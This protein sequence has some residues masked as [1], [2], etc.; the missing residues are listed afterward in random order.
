MITRV[1]CGFPGVGK[2][3]FVDNNMGSYK[4]IDSDSSSYSW[5]SEGVRNPAFPENYIEHIK[6]NVG[7]VGFIFVSTHKEVIDAL[8]ETGIKFELVY[9]DIE[10]KDE[11][12]KRFKDRGDDDSFIELMDKNWESFIGS[13][14]EREGVDKTVL[15]SS[16][17]LEKFRYKR[18]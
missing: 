15:R 18:G 10:L 16:E 1:I 7:K 2:T 5:L 11:Y 6:S 12:L 8:D 17:Y 3:H 9:P 13:L 4:A 14:R